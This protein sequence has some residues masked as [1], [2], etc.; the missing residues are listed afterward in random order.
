MSGIDTRLLRYFAAV[1]DEQRFGRAALRLDITPPTLT[2]QIEKLESRLG[3][4]LFER[5]Q[6]S[7]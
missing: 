6:Q 1:V 5:P 2:D 3:V 7:R 4:K